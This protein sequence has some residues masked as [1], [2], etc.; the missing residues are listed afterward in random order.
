MRRFFAKQQL[1]L[2]L[3]QQLMKARAIYDYIMFKKAELNFQYQ[4]KGFTNFE[5]VRAKYGEIKKVLKDKLAGYDSSGKGVPAAL[6]KEL[7]PLEA[8]RRILEDAIDKYD[9]F[10]KHLAEKKEMIYETQYYLARVKEGATDW[11]KESDKFVPVNVLSE[12]EV[13]GKANE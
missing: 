5:A 1:L 8:E 12:E 2:E 7:E 10:E 9:G 11:L 13:G 4:E 6:V 3:E